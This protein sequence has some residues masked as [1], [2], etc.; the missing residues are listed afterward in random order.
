MA[1]PLQ[2]LLLKIQSPSLNAV[3]SNLYTDQRDVRVI[4]NHRV[5]V[6]VIS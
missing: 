3:L 2:G 5:C 6:N 4:A 1:L